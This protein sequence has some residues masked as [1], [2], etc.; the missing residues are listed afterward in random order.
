MNILHNFWITQLI[1]PLVSFAQDFDFPLK[2][3]LIVNSYFGEIRPNHFHAGLDLHTP[4]NRPLELIA[5]EAG[6]VSRIRVG[7]HGYGKAV[8]L[9]HPN[10]KVSVY[11]HLSKFSEKISNYILHQQSLKEIFE[12]DINLEK[13]E[14]PISRK[15]CIGY[16]GNT[17]NSTGPHLHFEIRD[18]KT[19]VAL[20]P[21]LFFDLA[22][23]IPPTL[24][25]LFFFETE[26]LNNLKPL[27]SIEINKLNITHA[28]SEKKRNEYI[29]KEP[30]ELPDKFG[31]GI[32][33]YDLIK[34][35][36]AHFQIYEAKLKYN[37]DI[38]F[39]FKLDSISFDESAYVNCFTNPIGGLKHKKIMKCFLHKNE[40][41]RIVKVEK[42]NGF[43]TLN[44]NSVNNF[45]IELS[46]I[47]GNS[48]CY[49]FSIHKKEFPKIPHKEFKFNCEEDQQISKP[50]FSLKIQKKSAFND[51]NLET[52]E[53]K[54]QANKYSDILEI[55][56][57]AP[58][59]LYPASIGIKV[60]EIGNLNPEKLYV[61]NISTQSYCGGNFQDGMIFGKSKA[62]GKFELRADSTGPK[63]EL[64]TKGIKETENL[65]KIVFKVKD[66]ESGIKEFRMTING[67]WVYSE[68]EHKENLIYH[69]FTKNDYKEKLKIN[70]LI[71]D[72]RDN[73]SEYSHEF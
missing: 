63:I 52:I 11:A 26:D 68:Y 54:N 55:T 3:Q 33:A 39:H 8:Y 27:K 73:S 36:N 17:G 24:N 15:E 72:N 34:K 70:L 18:E 69:E 23:Q 5:I 51:Y 25:E 58:P 9:T 71:K 64:L 35:N 7:T 10:G 4:D 66:L 48:S 61:F 20:N 47:K 42:N 43:I 60:K 49:R 16:S 12:I 53:W 28:K 14:I 44:E 46:D 1:F 38:V 65:Q 30:L 21:L 29:I 22:D 2:D 50:N 56:G 45:E 6:Y 32:S 40:K 62:L 13:N 41:L 37:A 67:K 31:I 59:L 57:I 19:E